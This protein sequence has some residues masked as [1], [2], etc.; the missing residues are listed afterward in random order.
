M[1]VFITGATGFI[2]AHLVPELLQAGHHVIGLCRSE[3]GAKKLAQAGA[4]P[5]FGDVND[6]SRL[7]AGALSADGVIHTAFN[8]DFARVRQ[9]SEEDRA[10]IEAL[11]EAL[12]GSGKPLIVT[13]GTG[14]VE[15]RLGEDCVIET[16]THAG[17]AKTPRAATEEAANAILAKN[18]HVIVMRL[19]QVHDTHHQGRIAHHIRLAKEKGYVAYIGDG[20]NRLPA[21]HVAD[22]VRLFRVALEHGR[23]GGF[24]HAVAEEGVAMREIAQVIGTGLRL[25]VESITADAASSYF[26]VLAGLASLDL[27]ASGDLTRQELGWTP[28]GPSL[29]SDLRQMEWASH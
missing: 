20:Q 10:V 22:A 15:R 23:P 6:L 12:T 9:H 25:P 19:P 1:R 16:D 2:G 24:Y 8:H 14:L 17:S 4:E 7:R 5:F 21:V 28:T 27:A 13:S 26:G 3:E 18:V 29:L 11:G